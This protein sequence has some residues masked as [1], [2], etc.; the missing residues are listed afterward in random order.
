MN[1]IAIL[2]GKGGTGKTSISAAFATIDKNMVVCD[3]DVD[4]AN[5]YIVLQPVD[6]REEIFIS[7]YKAEID[8]DLCYNCGLCVDYCRFGAISHSNGRVEIIETSCDG[9]KLCSRICPAK[10][11]NMIPGNKSRWYSGCYRNGFMV[12][13]RLAPGEENSG[14]LVN[15]V[16]E[17]SRK[18]ASENDIDIIVI[19]GPPGIGCSAI[20]T[21]TGVNKVIVVTEPSMSGFHDLQRILEL[22]AGFSVKSYVVINKYDL[23][24]DLTRK[25]EEWCN[26]INIS[27]IGKIPFDEQVVEA[28]LQCKSIVELK[29]DSPVSIEI[30]KIW[31]FVSLNKCGLSDIVDQ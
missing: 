5:L 28:M 4:A 6:N 18:I 25:I 11:I 20:S 22:T 10:A 15:I 12:H 17:Q 14:K 30:K 1:E 24:P 7:G 8:Y 29:P 16:R 23:N 13:A 31:S 26:T 27:V 9:C 21:I 2:S 3:C 19:D